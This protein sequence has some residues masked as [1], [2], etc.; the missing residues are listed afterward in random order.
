MKG[1]WKEN[2][3]D[4]FRFLEPNNRETVD[5]YSGPIPDDDEESKND[6]YYIDFTPDDDQI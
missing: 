2:G 5:P 4:M 6:C 1:A 3:N